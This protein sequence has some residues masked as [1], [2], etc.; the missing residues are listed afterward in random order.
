MLEISTPQ[1]RVPINTKHK[2]RYIG[3]YISSHFIKLLAKRAQESLYA[4]WQNK[5]RTYYVMT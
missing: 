1:T 3:S 2:V 4:K 5:P